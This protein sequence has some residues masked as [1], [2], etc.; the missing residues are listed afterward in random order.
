METSNKNSCTELTTTKPRLVERRTGLR[1][2]GIGAVPP[3]GGRVRKN[4]E[5]DLRERDPEIP[6]WTLEAAHRDL[7]CSLMERQDR[8]NEELLQKIIDLQYR[9]DDHEAD[10]AERGRKTGRTPEAQK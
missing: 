3:T 5:D 6:Y 9:M 1:G 10:H 7:V 8:V 4:T 2:L